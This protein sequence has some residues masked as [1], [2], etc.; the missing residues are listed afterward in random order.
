MVTQMEVFKS[1]SQIVL[2][3]SMLNESIL[4]LWMRELTMVY[5]LLANGLGSTSWPKVRNTS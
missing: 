4:I 5:N 3:G 2:D 1:P